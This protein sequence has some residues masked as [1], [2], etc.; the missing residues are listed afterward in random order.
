MEHLLRKII[1]ETLR[2]NLQQAEKAYVKTGLLSQQDI[3]RVV[4]ITGGDGFTKFMC[5]LLP[6]EDLMYDFPLTQVHRELKAYNKNLFPI[7]GME[8]MNA[9]EGNA[10]FELYKALQHRRDA[11]EMYHRLPSV[12][13]RNMKNEARTPRNSS[14]MEKLF[15]NLRRLVIYLG[16]LDNRTPEQREKVFAKLF[17]SRNKTIDDWLGFMEEYANYEEP[18]S[19]LQDLY[20]IIQENDCSIVQ[21]TDDVVVV[22][23]FDHSA[24]KALGCNSRWCF[25]YPHSQDYWWDYSTN[26]MVYYIFNKNDL[27]DQYVLTAPNDLYDV[28]NT[29]VRAV[30]DRL[31][32]L[33]V[34]RS[35]LTFEPPE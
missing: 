30:E 15:T 35:K 3:S 12:A 6:H 7:I 21:D 27:Y 20:R 33:G 5:A 10:A 9:A 13:I 23:V 18:A 32:I 26:D 22:A 8:N 16:F 34:D 14:L 2:E 24:I 31:N 29:K 19:S 17:S 28:S 25:A 4:A 11:I 1:R